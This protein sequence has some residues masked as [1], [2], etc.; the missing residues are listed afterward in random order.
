M[1]LFHDF[2]FTEAHRLRKQDSSFKCLFT[3]CGW[4]EGEVGRQ[5]LPAALKIREGL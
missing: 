1:C 3:K 5:E 4:E 2:T